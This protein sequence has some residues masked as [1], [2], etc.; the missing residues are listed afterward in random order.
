MILARI[1][2]IFLY[3][4]L[5]KITLRIMLNYF[6]EKKKPFLTI[7]KTEFFKV[8]KITFFSK[9]LTHAFGQKMPFF[10]YFYWIKVRLEIMLFNFEEKKIF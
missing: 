4:Y 3:L 1:C 7:K 9:G 2:Q 6:E 10:L 8:Q 5:V